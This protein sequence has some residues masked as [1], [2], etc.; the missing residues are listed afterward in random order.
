[1][2]WVALLNFAPDKW[3]DRMDTI[4]TYEQDSSVSSRLWMWRVSWTVALERPVLGGGFH[5]GW[6]VPY[7][8][9]V[10]AGSRLDP[11]VKPRAAHSIWFQQLGDHGFIGL[12]LLVGFF[13]IAVVDA[14]W[15]IRNTKAVNPGLAWANHF[16]RM[17]QAS[18][19]GFGVGGI[20][21]SLNMYDG[22]YALV[23]LGAAARRLVAAD[24]AAQARATRTSKPLRP[25]PLPTPA[26]VR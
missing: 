14:R 23:M 22:F 17:L 25:T 26:L 7:T 20:T 5:W 21:L 16:G 6:N 19:V 4:Q 18:M 8:N 13:V 2:P 15:L 3:F 9:A 1:M 11:F 12:G 10:L 24:L